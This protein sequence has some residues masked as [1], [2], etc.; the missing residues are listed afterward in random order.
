LTRKIYVRASIGTLAKLGLL[1]LKYSES[2]TTAYLLQ[3][4]PIGCSGGCR[5]CLQSRRALSRSSDKLGRVTWPTVDL[6][7]LA[8]SWKSVF[9]RVCLQTVIKPGFHL[10]ALEILRFIRSFEYVKPLSLA[11]TPVPKHILEEAR[12]LGV[13]SLGVGLDVATKG[14]F[15]AWGKPYSWDLYWLFIKRGVEVYGAGSVYVHLIAGLGESLRELVYAMKRIYELGGRVALFN[16]IN[17]KGTSPVSIQ[18]YRL[19]QIARLLLEQGLNPDE[20]IDYEHLKT[21][22]DIPV[23]RLEEAFYTSGCPGCNRPFYNESP[24][25]PIYNI[26]SRQMLDAYIERLR[27]ELGSIGVHL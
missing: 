8:S 10:E 13:D 19:A 1:D 3:Y 26:P 7:T 15:E 22:R 6:E 12:K 16:Y 27:E 17:E 23:N 21:V 25:G 24:R 9:T 11:I 14:L 5:F 20:Y 2:P 4:S 18:Y